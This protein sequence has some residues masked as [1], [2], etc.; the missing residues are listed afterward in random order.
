MVI[1][2][3]TINIQLNNNSFVLCK[4]FHQ[5]KHF[6]VCSVSDGDKK[7]YQIVIDDKPRYY[8]VI[9]LYN[10]RAAFWLSNYLEKHSDCSA[11][12]TG[13]EQYIK[14][15][16]KDILINYCL[17]KHLYNVFIGRRRLAYYR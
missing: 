6:I 2:M 16:F 11:I 1:D 7:G 8:R 14:L 3:E 4:V 5:T 15:T 12:L 10:K 13:N 17:D 9:K